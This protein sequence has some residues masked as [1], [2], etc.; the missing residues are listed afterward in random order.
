MA[1][2]SIRVLLVDRGSGLRLRGA[3]PVTD[4]L[5]RVHS[6][7]WGLWPAGALCVS[8]L[9]GQGS[10]LPCS[11]GFDPEEPAQ[12]G[13][14]PRMAELCSDG[15]TARGSGPGVERGCTR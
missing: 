11:T 8:R 14:H 4:P 12:F 5:V 10:V 1:S 2:G 13:P 9:N 3:S 15:R 6:I 7:P